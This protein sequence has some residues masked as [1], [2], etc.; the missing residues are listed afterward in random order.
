MLAAPGYTPPVGVPKV[1]VESRTKSVPPVDLVNSPAEMPSG[2][3][4]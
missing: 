2:V 3:A 1:G 4:P